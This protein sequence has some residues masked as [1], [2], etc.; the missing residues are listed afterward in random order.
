MLR[1]NTQKKQ[2][3]G[4]VI[5][6]GTVQSKYLLIIQKT[7][8]FHSIFHSIFRYFFA[9]FK[10]IRVFFHPIYF[11]STLFYPNFFVSTLD[12]RDFV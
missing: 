7:I 6:N 12:N 4:T 2:P 5:Q 8:N 11:F 3:N 10:N 1:K 9:Q